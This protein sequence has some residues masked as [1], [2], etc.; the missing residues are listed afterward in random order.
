MWKKLKTYLF[1][2]RFVYRPYNTACS[3]T[4][5]VLQRTEIW[6][7]SVRWQMW[8]IVVPRALSLPPRERFLGTLGVDR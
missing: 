8:T 3:F 6:K 1:T 7:R 4:E 2:F 5:I